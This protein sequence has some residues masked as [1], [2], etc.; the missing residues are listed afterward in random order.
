MRS[1]V[2]VLLVLGLALALVADSD[3]RRR[4]RRGRGTSGGDPIDAAAKAAA[5]KAAE[6][7]AAE[8]KA[9]AAKKLTANVADIHPDCKGRDELCAAGESCVLTGLYL[10][11]SK[12]YECA[13]K[14]W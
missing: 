2:R 3:A 7:K 13:K 5:A 11:S 10:D 4:R 12:R 14:N 6:A 9:A 1:S 8:A